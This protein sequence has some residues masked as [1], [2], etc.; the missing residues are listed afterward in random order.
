LTQQDLPTLVEQCR[1]QMQQ[2]I[3]RMEGELANH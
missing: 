3:D 2:C 1:A